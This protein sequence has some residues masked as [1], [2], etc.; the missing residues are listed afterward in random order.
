MHAS[1]IMPSHTLISQLLDNNAGR[2]SALIS[3]H[4]MLD[5]FPDASASL[6]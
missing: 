4:S 6:N 2:L 1:E 3:V 5:R